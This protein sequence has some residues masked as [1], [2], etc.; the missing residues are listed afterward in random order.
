MSIYYAPLG[1]SITQP[2]KELDLKKKK[3]QN[4]CISEFQDIQ[5]YTEKKKMPIIIINNFGMSAKIQMILFTY[6]YLFHA[7]NI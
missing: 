6:F 5:G 3:K 2:V 4:R 7:T 1:L